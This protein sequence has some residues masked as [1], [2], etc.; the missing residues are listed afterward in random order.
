MHWTAIESTTATKARCGSLRI[1]KRGVLVNTPCTLNYTRQGAIPHIVDPSTTLPVTSSTPI[2]LNIALEHFADSAETTETQCSRSQSSHAFDADLPKKPLASDSSLSRLGLNIP[3][4]ILVATPHDM[5]R[6]TTLAHGRWI[7]STKTSISMLAN[8][9][10]E[11][12]ITPKTFMELVNSIQPDIAICIADPGLVLYSANSGDKANVSAAINTKRQR[13]QANADTIIGT[14]S[15]AGQDD[16]AAH[17]EIRRKKLLRKQSDRNLTFLKSVAQILATP[18]PNSGSYFDSVTTISTT[19]KTTVAESSPPPCQDRVAMFAHL[20]GGIDLEER[21]FYSTQV[22]QYFINP[23]VTISGV[24]V[25]LPSQEVRKASGCVITA[26]LDASLGSIPFHVPVIA[27][28][29]SSIQDLVSCVASGVDM[30]DN[31]WIYTLTQK[32]IALVASFRSQVNPVSK[33]QSLD[34]VVEHSLSKTPCMPSTHISDATDNMPS[35]QND[36]DIGQSHLNEVLMDLS[37]QTALK[38]QTK[39]SRMQFQPAVAAVVDALVASESVDYVHETD[40]PAI[41]VIEKDTEELESIARPLSHL[42]TDMDPI[43]AL[44][45][46]WTCKQP[47]SKA[48]IRHLLVVNDMLAYVLLMHHNMWQFESFVGEMRECVS[49]GSFEKYATRFLSPYSHKMEH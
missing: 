4:H 35:K 12:G 38:S 24:A 5:V 13:V 49:D 15:S 3:S 46:C 17:Q 29:V 16:D 14:N 9:N 44:C 18:D 43:D 22:A 45:G 32:G 42:Q 34:I 39:R 48:Y 1:F 30:I 20:C 25:T 23:D 31:S 28:G 10:I 37:P 40:V 21:L 19:H 2:A 33:D 26:F 11:L 41:A 27:L 7:T 47:Y 36:L 8:G 6:L